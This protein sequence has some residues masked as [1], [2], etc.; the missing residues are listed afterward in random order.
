MMS[1]ERKDFE[2]YIQKRSNLDYGQRL[3][4]LGF[5]KGMQLADDMKTLSVSKEANMSCLED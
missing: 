5:V 2:E 4:L 3:I 1:E